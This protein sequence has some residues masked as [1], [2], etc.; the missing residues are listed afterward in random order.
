MPT[1]L[2]SSILDTSFSLSK[3]LSE[4][5]FELPSN[6]KLADMGDTAPNHVL[7]SY[8]MLDL[9]VLNQD[10]LHVF[11]RNCVRFYVRVFAQDLEGDEQI[12][13]E[14]ARFR[15]DLDDPDTMFE[16]E[17]WVLDAIEDEISILAPAPS[18][19]TRKPITLLDYF[20]P[21][22]FA[23]RL[24]N[25]KG[26]LI[27]I[28]EIYNP[29]HH[30]DTSPRTRIVDTVPEIRR[31]RDHRTG[32]QGDVLRSALPSVPLILAS[33]LERIDDGLEDAD[34]S[35][36]PKKVRRVGTNEVL[37]FKG[38]FK[39]HGHLRE[40][41][42]LSKTEASRKFTPPFRTSKLVGLVV[43]DDDEDY[44]MGLLLEFIEG[45]SLFSL[46]TTEPTTTKTKWFSQVKMTVKRLHEAGLVWGDAKS[47]NVLINE[48][49]DVVVIDF[50]GGY[51]PEYIPRE[52]QDTVEG[53]LMALKRMA[54]ELGVEYETV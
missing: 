29:Q 36:I 42:I 9:E 54:A 52:L 44:L 30:G 15:D 16:F 3:P 34:L 35:D 28:K 22:T 50:G 43:W 37:F 5:T 24:V 47:D 31:Q 41:D 14:F 39:Y 6:P 45:E 26:T 8:C 51:T 17:E 38:G 4:H 19:G 33:Q 48:A 21:P 12:F 10:I 23:F 13:G 53:D 1:D 7:P 49:G 46:S 2:P 11:M 27:A 20:R 40:I 25:Q 32:D 18:P